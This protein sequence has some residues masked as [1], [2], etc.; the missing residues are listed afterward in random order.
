LERGEH[1]DKEE[2]WHRFGSLQFSLC[3]TSPLEKS[4]NVARRD[5]TYRDF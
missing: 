4:P 5:T 2:T 1:N 3:D